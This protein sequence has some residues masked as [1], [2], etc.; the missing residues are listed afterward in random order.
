MCAALER[1]YENRSRRKEGN[2]YA[3]PQCPSHNARV[4]KPRASIDAALPKRKAAHNK[5]ALHARKVDAGSR[6]LVM[7]IHRPRSTQRCFVHLHTMESVCR[8]LQN[9]KW[10]HGR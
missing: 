6:G 3:N 1:S 7:A 9:T 2:T 4:C 5:S 10:A 8:R